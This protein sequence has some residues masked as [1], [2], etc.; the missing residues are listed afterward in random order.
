[1]LSIH[2]LTCY[3]LGAFAVLIMVFMAVTSAMS[4]ETLATT[5]LLT[6]DFYQAYINPKATGKQLVDF[7][8]YI[9]VG[10]G[11]VVASVTVGRNH[12]GFSVNYLV[13]AIGIIVDSAIIPSML[14]LDKAL[15]RS[16][17][18]IISSISTN[19]F[20]N[21]A[22]SITFTLKYKILTQPTQST[23]TIPV[24]GIETVNF[25]FLVDFVTIMIGSVSAIFNP[26]IHRSIIYNA[27]GTIT[28]A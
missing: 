23:G 3:N 27:N 2:R 9:V 14:F 5:A 12:A 22:S 20:N 26:Q 4:S 15:S 18:R 1:M 21:S 28:V 19:I 10:F 11:I 25:P 7:S 13:T 17:E 8:H 6:Y 16:I 24:G